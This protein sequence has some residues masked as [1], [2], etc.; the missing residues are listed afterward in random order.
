MAGREKEY[1]RLPG[2][3]MG[4]GVG[5]YF[6]VLSLRNRLWLGKDHLLAVESQ[7]YSERYRRFYFSDIQAIVCRKIY[8]DLVINIALGVVAAGSLV[9]A[10]FALS[11]DAVPFSIFLFVMTG[12]LAA[13]ITVNWL[14]GPACVCHVRTAVQQ[15]ELPSLRRIRTA[16]RVLRR[17]RPFIEQAQGGAIETDA[18][19][20]AVAA[21]G[22]EAARAGGS[23]RRKQVRWRRNQR[24][25]SLSSNRT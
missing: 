14:I 8:S 10:L 23:S 6:S 18:V 16:R 4:G 13:I 2:V 25:A 15:E 7:G 12:L 5:R 3:G 20:E 22:L 9:G 21:G 19:R 1:R 24:V 11:A 17:I